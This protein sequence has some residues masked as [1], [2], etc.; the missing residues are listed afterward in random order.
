MFD[1]S[2]IE[3]VARNCVA[4]GIAGFIQPMI[5]NALDTI[6][7]RYQTAAAGPA[8]DGGLSKFVS[9]TIAREGIIRGFY[10]P[11]LLQNMSGVC[12]SQ[13]LRIGI[14]PTVRDSLGKAVGAEGKSAGTMA[15]AG[16]LSGAL[17]YFLT[18]PV[19]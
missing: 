10:L 15:F 1:K 13:G 14:Y 5:F 3:I 18:A 19:W 9:R 8:N 12:L 7:L 17:A 2:E 4:A 6:R 11:G 16:L